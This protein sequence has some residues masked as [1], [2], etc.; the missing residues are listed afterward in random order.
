MRTPLSA[1]A[2]R[3]VRGGNGSPGPVVRVLVADDSEAF[4]RAAAQVIEVCPGF[5]LAATAASGEEAIELTGHLRPDLVLVDIRMPGMGGVAAAEEI[6]ASAPGAEVVLISGG[7]R[8]DA[9]GMA[10]SS[11]PYL[12]KS[13]FGPD[14]LRALWLGRVAG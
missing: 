9:P 5:E 7:P 1:A 6:A 14:A 12:A 11:R 13:S 8:E 10:A 2:A 4:Q 3:P